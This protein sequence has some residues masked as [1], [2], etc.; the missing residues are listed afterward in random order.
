MF[1]SNCGK[2]IEDNAKFCKYCGKNFVSNSENNTENN[3]INANRLTLGDV[4]VGGI[5]LFV[6]IFFIR[7]CNNS[8]P[9]N[10][11]SKMSE[12]QRQER[13][14]ITNDFMVEA[15]NGGLVTKINKECTADGEFCTYYIRV[16]ENM[17]NMF[18]FED[19]ENFN[20]F[21]QEYAELRSKEAAATVEGT[22]SGKVLADK[23]KG[24]VRQ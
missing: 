6:I 14:K 24:V 8:E 3:N 9:L 17:W 13:M 10:T 11:T 2:E 7:G 5:I 15:Q 23:F 16:K 22:Y 20:K 12:E 4:V 1:C 18:T 19:K 21:V